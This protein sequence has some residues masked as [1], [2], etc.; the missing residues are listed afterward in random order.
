MKKRIL[1]AIHYLELGGAE[2]SLIGLLQVMDYSK[3]D[4]DLFVYSH[5]GELMKYIPDQVNLL[6]EIPEYAQIERPIKSV[7]K[8]GYW[9]IALRRFLAKYPARRF[10][11][12]YP[13]E[14]SAVG[15]Q[16]VA[17]Y[18]T[19]VL[20]A[21]NPGIEYDL[22]VSF[23]T[24]HNIVRDKV[25]AKKKV[26]WIHTDYSVVS[27]D[28]RVES[29]VWMSYNK[30]V[31]VSDDVTK[32]FLTVF[33]EAESKIVSIENI[34]SPDFVTRRS[35]EFDA[36]PE[37]LKHY[38]G[39]NPIIILTVGRFCYPKNM[40]SIPSILGEI[41]ALLPERQEDIKWFIIGYGPDR[42]I[43]KRSISEA[44][45]EDRVILLGKRS[46][47]YPYIKACDLYVQPSRYEGKAV[48]V[49]EAQ[50]LCKPVVVTNYPTAKSQVLD[51]RDGIIIPMD[52][53]GC[54]EGIVSLIKDRERQGR[55]VSYL[56]EHDFGNE[57][58]VEKFY[59]LI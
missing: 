46:N 45:M 55:L 13:S 37:Y 43:I 52:V 8:D 31:S 42:D 2:I 7:I 50:M 57:S 19:P 26:A 5:R 40:D 14:D 34:L 47:P 4:V 54:A 56:K 35:E 58:E 1:I 9:R 20:P 44:G 10:A 24:P 28:A 27:V 48:T 53:K 59:S 33:P 29:P 51:G 38:Q 32:S 12:R 49:R 17:N 3:Y 18:V 11:R 23:L 25:R 16:Y 22:A 36:L 21:I 6:P 30:I 39:G 41:N 15:L